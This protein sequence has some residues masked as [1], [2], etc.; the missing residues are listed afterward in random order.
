MSDPSKPGSPDPA[1]E[2]ERLRELILG[3]RG[4]HL[5]AL[6]RRVEDPATRTGDVAEVLS[7]NVSTIFL[8]STTPLRWLQQHPRRSPL[9]SYWLGVSDGVPNVDKQCPVINLNIK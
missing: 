6:S 7:E 9:P 5:D 4:T 2:L 8:F 3:D 1:D